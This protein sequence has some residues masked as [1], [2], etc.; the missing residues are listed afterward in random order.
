LQVLTVQ[1]SPSSQSPQVIA[2]PHPSSR[3]P[4]TTPS[5]AQVSGWQQRSSPMQSAPFGQHSPPQHCWSGLQQSPPQGAFPEAQQLPVTV[6][7]P[8]QQVFGLPFWSRQQAS[9]EPQQPA[10]PQA[11]APLS[12]HTPLWH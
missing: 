10:P 4:Q 3:T 8:A 11:V 6:H 7:E 5:S 2:P 1:G 12:Q 9:P